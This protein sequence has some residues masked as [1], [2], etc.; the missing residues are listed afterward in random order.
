MQR[1]DFARMFVVPLLSSFTAR[2]FADIRGV[3]LLYLG[4]I[5]IILA[6]AV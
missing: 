6:A 4:F 5:H 2:I 1:M 3:L